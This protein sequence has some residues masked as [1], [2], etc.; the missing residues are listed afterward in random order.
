MKKSIKF[1]VVLVVFLLISMGLKKSGIDFVRFV[2]NKAKVVTGSIPTNSSNHTTK[3]LVKNQTDSLSQLALGQ[4]TTPNKSIANSKKI[5]RIYGRK[6]RKQ[7]RKEY[8]DKGGKLRVDKDG[9]LIEFMHYDKQGKPKYLMTSNVNAALTANIPPVAQAPYLLDGGGEV[10]GVWD[11]GCAM[12]NHVDFNNGGTPRLLVNDDSSPHWHST[13][14]AG[15]IASSDVDDPLSLGMSPATRIFSYDWFSDI[16]EMATVAARTADHIDHI[17]L[18]NHSYGVPTGWATSPVEGASLHWYGEFSPTGQVEDRDFGNYNINAMELD[19]VTTAFPYLLPFVA[20]GNDRANVPNDG[21]TVSYYDPGDDSN[22]TVIYDSSVHPK[23]NNHKGGY[24]TISNAGLAKNIITVGAVNDA[25]D[26]GERSLV[27]ATMSSFS[28]WGPCDDGR[29]KPDIVANGVALFSAYYDPARPENNSLHGYGTGTSMASPSV[30]GSAN[31]IQSYYLNSFGQHLLGATLKALL[32]HTADDLG[33][34]GPDYINGW[35]LVNVEEAVKRID[36]QITDPFT[37]IIR[38]CTILN[39][40]THSYTIYSTGSGPLK[41]TIVWND[42]AA[43]EFYPNDLDVPHQMLV[44]DLDLKVIDSLGHE[45]FPWVLDV[46]NPSSA[47]V[48]G[49]NRVDN[50]EQVLIQDPV[51]G[52]YTVEISHKGDLKYRAQNYSLITSGCTTR[53]KEIENLPITHNS[54][55]LLLNERATI[56]NGSDLGKFVKNS[57]S[58]IKTLQIQNTSLNAVTLSNISISNS[59]AVS[60]VNYPTSLAAG[61][62]GNISVKIDTNVLDG[63]DQF[64]LTVEQAT[65]VYNF[66]MQCEAVVENFPHSTWS[67]AWEGEENWVVDDLIHA[68]GSLRSFRSK[69]I[70]HE[71]EVALNYSGQVDDG[72]V[73]FKVKISS[74]RDWDLFKFSIDSVE[75]V[76]VPE[77]S[78]IAISGEMGWLSF[79]KLIAAGHHTFSW[80]YAMDQ[81]VSRGYSAVWLDEVILPELETEK[82]VTFLASEGGNISGDLTQRV[83]SGADCSQITAT[84]LPGYKFDYW[85]DGQGTNTG[86]TANPLMVTNVTEPATYRACFF[87]EMPESIINLNISQDG[88][89]VTWSVEDESGIKEYHIIDAQ[90]NALIGTKL[91]TDGP[92]Y[93][94]ELSEALNIKLVIVY[95]NDFERII[96]PPFNSIEVKVVYDLVSGWNLISMVGE[97]PDMT[98]LLAVSTGQFWGWK[99]GIYDP[100]TEPAPYEGFWIYSTEKKRVTV[101]AIESDQSMLLEAGWN[102]VG[103]KEAV[104]KPAEA[105]FVFAWNPGYKL[106]LANEFMIPGVGYWVFVASDND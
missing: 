80:V 27:N 1:L 68:D 8:E 33:Q 35:G 99:N 74:E 94:F 38:E 58:Y 87:K 52:V 85:D 49:N 97:A 26:N 91:V 100:I 21:D 78:S 59:V 93:S 60:I 9:V 96:A 22:K 103:S 65:E 48:T 88:L 41:V 102:L 86:L 95:L 70:D 79:S 98:E 4:T 18:S 2:S 63:I 64:Q 47:A 66:E 36:N 3:P 76:L 37:P 72:E 32:I 53:E 13:H 12:A 31:L 7:A 29:I 105:L 82:Q 42:V 24:D 17:Y 75:Q 5:D 71:E 30:A 40:E 20:A 28:C 39:N 14:V 15:T 62:Y 43:T 61:D 51:E 81:A 92:S 19:D 55:H 46:T 34:V 56:Q 16:E 50:V 25:V 6:N 73:A 83:D 23:G 11:G 44:N 69:K 45:S 77:T 104:N 89:T 101:T 106:L 67:S 57:G 84:P 90:T 54:K 10:V